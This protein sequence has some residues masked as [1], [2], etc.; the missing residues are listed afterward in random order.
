[1]YTVHA[2]SCLIHVYVSLSSNYVRKQLWWWPEGNHGRRG[3]NRLTGGIMCLFFSISVS[4][5]N[6]KEMQRMKWD[7]YI[8]DVKQVQSDTNRILEVD[9]RLSSTPDFLSV[10]FKSVN[11][12][13]FLLLF[14]LI[15]NESWFKR[16]SSFLLMHFEQSVSQKDPPP[17][18]D[19]TVY[20]VSQI[21]P[22]QYWY[23]AFCWTVLNDVWRKW[24]RL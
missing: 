13:L 18:S 5:K 17:H 24:R 7:K 19:I 1:M 9:V 15:I 23:T 4:E 8:N 21:Q 20:S 14:L 6:Q 3:G 2:E 16:I 22:S 12:F 10:K 11:N